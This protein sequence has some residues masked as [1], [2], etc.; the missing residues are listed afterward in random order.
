MKRQIIG[1]ILTVVLLVLPSIFLSV[2]CSDGDDDDVEYVETICHGRRRVMADLT[3]VTGIIAEGC[4]FM[5]RPDD[6]PSGYLTLG[7]G[8]DYLLP[9]EFRDDG[10][11]VRFSGRI[12]E[13]FQTEDFC[14]RFDAELFELSGIELVEN[15]DDDFESICHGRR[16]VMAD[17]T[18]VT[19]T[20]E[21]D[22]DCGFML[23][24]DDPLLLPE[25][26]AAYLGVNGCGLL[27][28]EFK[29]DGVRVRFSGRIF[30][31][32]PREDFCADPFELSG[33]ELIEP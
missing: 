23:R 32:F 28:E 16:R 12:L 33:I 20:I 18:D 24:P 6:P 7:R 26:T 22:E 30:E 19:G 29:I 13:T 11:R 15:G 14:S 9:E 1:S 17:L 10:I 5:L 27:P 21:I 4:G 3:D 25:D 2:S 31:T 8:C